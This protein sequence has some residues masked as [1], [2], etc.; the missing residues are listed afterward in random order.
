M[1]F[2]SANALVTIFILTPAADPKE[3]EEYTF[4]ACGKVR[5][6]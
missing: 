6:Y 3:D 1:I 5:K 4:N 2:I